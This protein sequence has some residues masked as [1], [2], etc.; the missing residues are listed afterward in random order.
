[1]DSRHFGSLGHCNRRCRDRS[2]QRPSASTSE[3][4]LSAFDTPQ[5]QTRD[6]DKREPSCPYSHLNTIMGPAVRRA[7]KTHHWPGVTPSMKNM[8]GAM[9]GSVYGWP[10]NVL[11]RKGNRTEHPGFVAISES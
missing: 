1:M 7:V 8:F 6:Q 11:H 3:P 10:K 5:L 4:Y 2:N 9:P